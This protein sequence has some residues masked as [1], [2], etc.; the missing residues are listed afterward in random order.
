ME[1]ANEA[2]L[3]THG[4][5]CV[6]GPAIAAISKKILGIDKHI[7]AAANNINDRL[8]K[9]LNEEDERLKN[10]SLEETPTIFILDLNMPENEKN[11]LLMNRLSKRGNV[12]YLDHHNNSL[13]IKEYAN[14]DNNFYAYI[15]KDSKSSFHDYY[16]ILVQNALGNEKKMELPDKFV[17]R[18]DV[19]ELEPFKPLVKAMDIIDG[20]D[21]DNMMDYVHIQWI[22]YIKCHDNENKRIN[23]EMYSQIIMENPHIGLSEAEL[24]DSG[25]LEELIGPDRMKEYFEYKSE[26]KEAIRKADEA[27]KEIVE[28]GKMRRLYDRLDNRFIRVVCPR[29]MQACYSENF[30]GNFIMKYCKELNFK[31]NPTYVEILKMNTVKTYK[32]SRQKYIPVLMITDKEDINLSKVSMSKGGGGHEKIAGYDLQRARLDNSVKK[33][34]DGYEMRE[35]KYVIRSHSGHGKLHIKRALSTF[36]LRGRTRRLNLNNNRSDEMRVT[37]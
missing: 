25:L 16:D 1:K 5:G 2:I 18:I 12:V 29:D 14:K 4:E 36:A 7:F 33:I 34:D 8:E 3:F 17:S 35:N 6:E 9:Y 27:A 22:K 10:G 15:N 13:W 23:N 11:K 37:L 20:F 21:I 19:N 26:K 28:K 32:K 24:I 31:F 30:L